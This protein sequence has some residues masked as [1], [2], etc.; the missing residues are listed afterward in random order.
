MSGEF[1]PDAAVNYL[2]NITSRYYLFNPEIVHLITGITTLENRSMGSL[3]MGYRVAEKK[4]QTQLICLAIGII[5]IVSTLPFVSSYLFGWDSAQFAFGIH[6][7]NIEKHQPHPPGFPV[8]IFLARMLYFF[9]GDAN[10]SLIGIMLTFSVAASVAYYL[11]IYDITGDRVLSVFSTLFFICNPVFW[12]NREVALTYAADALA[13][14][15]LPYLAYRIVYKHDARYIYP[16][17]ASLAIMGGV[18]SFLIPLFSLLFIYSLLHIRKESAGCAGPLSFTDFDFKKIMAGVVIFMVAI[19]LWFLPVSFLSGGPGHYLRVNSEYFNSIAKDSSWLS[20]APWRVT[21]TQIRLV[22]SALFAGITGIMIP[23][24]FLAIIKIK[25]AVMRKTADSGA[26]KTRTGTGALFVLC[27]IVPSLLIYGFVHFGNAGY[28]LT[29]VPVF[30][31]IATFGMK[32]MLTRRIGVIIL[33]MLL[34]LQ[35]SLFICMPSIYAL[36]MANPGKTEEYGTIM[37]L[38]YRYDPWL[39]LFNANTV[40]EFNARMQRIITEIDACMKKTGGGKKTLIL[41]PASDTLTGWRSYFRQLQYY[42]R[43]RTVTRVDNNG[44]ISADSGF[45]VFIPDTVRVADPPRNGN[46]IRRK[47]IYC[48][49][50]GDT[51]RIVLRDNLLMWSKK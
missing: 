49:H 20:G 51:D 3:R 26:E 31:I 33:A 9:L 39:L 15:L 37:K 1:S 47:T 5:T 48:C 16:L 19:L 42:Y 35:C 29:I 7:F 28:V 44:V 4:H 40:K 14:T 32:H 11:F 38:V 6:D 17:A 21:H 2:D 10:L 45:I 36:P 22:I 43:T 50:I 27:W 13:G 23:I 41:V 8:L 24:A 25:Q 12:F 18:R 34:A 30:H 46:L